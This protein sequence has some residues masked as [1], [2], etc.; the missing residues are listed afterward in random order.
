MNLSRWCWQI[1]CV[2]GLT[3][4]LCLASTSVAQDRAQK[5]SRKGKGADKPNIIQIDLSKLPPDVA[6][7][8]LELSKAQAT[9][10][11]MNQEDEDRDAKRKAKAKP[12]NERE[13]EDR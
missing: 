7:R 13:D 9:G 4:G 12:N 2:M 1:A 11:D 6:K 10:E 3:V 5:D 8:L